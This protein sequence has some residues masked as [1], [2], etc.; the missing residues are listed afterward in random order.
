MQLQRAVLLT[1]K[2][3]FLAADIGHIHVVGGW[4]EIFKFLGSENI[5]GDKMNLG[6]TVLSGLGGGHF[7]NLAR[8][9]LDHDETVLPQGRALH[10]VGGRSTGIGA[11]KSNIMLSKMVESAQ[12][13][14]H[15]AVV[16]GRS[17]CDLQPMAGQLHSDSK[18]Y[19]SVVVGHGDWCLSK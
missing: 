17:R 16:E 15:H 9:A 10:G 7:D 12:E 6:M 19:L 11:L 4:A 5:N 14:S 1:Y 3:V 8:T 2:L 13:H 18:S